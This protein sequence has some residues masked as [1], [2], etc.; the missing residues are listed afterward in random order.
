[1]EKRALRVRWLYL[2]LA[3]VVLVFGGIIYGWSILKE[4]LQAEFGWSANQLALNFTLVMSFFCLGGALGA[5]LSKRIKERGALLTAAI[6]AGGGFLLGTGMETVGMLYLAYGVMVGTGIGIAYNVVVSAV[7]AWFPDKKG[8]A[9]G[10]MMMG[11][12]SS[13]LIL[14]GLVSA[15]IQGPGWRSCFRILGLGNGL[16]L[17]AA[18]ILIKRPP[19]ALELPEQKKKDPVRREE[20]G[21][22]AL[23]CT[24]GE[25]VRR[26]SFW[27]AFF[28]LA[29]MSAVGNTT[30]SFT[31]QLAQ[32]V[33]ASAA[34]ATALVGVLSVCNGLGRLIYGA[35][36]DS[37]G[38][39]RTMQLSNVVA[40]SAACLSLLGVRVGSVPVCIA[41]LVVTGVS[42]GAGPVITP[43]LVR[44]FY[45]DQNFPLN[46]S[47]MNFSLMCAS[48]M[49]T[50]A[51]RIQ[52]AAGG[53][54]TAPMVF[55]VGLAVASWVFQT[56]VKEP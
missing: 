22:E 50:A 7:G 15:M 45:G 23:E 2:A 47:A 19:T 43:S 51:S 16:V 52:T 42:Y 8:L 28:Y 13:S 38:R 31:K 54:F 10:V 5:L 21:G 48:L 56:R 14:G 6:F 46:F 24:L 4:P 36:F 30:I 12:G 53:G 37:M 40:L 44:E 39:K 33:G 20:S 55:L 18:A 11:F 9:S 26:P 49:A 29:S 1:M 17:L 27:F 25:M 41:G 32:S 3:V 35:L 34:L